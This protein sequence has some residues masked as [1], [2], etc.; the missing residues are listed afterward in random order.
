MRFR[1]NIEQSAGV[2]NQTRSIE[3]GMEIRRCGCVCVR[4][5][6]KDD[7]SYHGAR[8]LQFPDHVLGRRS[9]SFPDVLK[10][11]VRQW[12]IRCKQSFHNNRAAIT[13]LS[14][15]LCKSTLLVVHSHL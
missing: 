2:S 10:H 3:Y 8:L 12:Q 7:S 13:T 14:L 15:Q 6:K 5:H 9:L 4:E 11:K 1:F